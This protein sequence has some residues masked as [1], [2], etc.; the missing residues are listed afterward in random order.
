M[1]ERPI[2]RC[3]CS[4]AAQYHKSGYFWARAEACPPALLW[5]P[6][7]S[8]FSAIK[9]ALP[10]AGGAEAA[11]H[12]HRVRPRTA[13]APTGLAEPRSAAQPGTEQSHTTVPGSRCRPGEGRQAEGG[14][15]APLRAG[16]GREPGS[17]AAPH[18]PRAC[19]GTASLSL[20]GPVGTR[21]P[22]AQH[23]GVGTLPDTLIQWENRQKS[24][25]NSQLTLLAVSHEGIPGRV[26]IGRTAGVCR[27]PERCSQDSRSSLLSFLFQL[28]VELEGRG[29]LGQILPWEAPTARQPPEAPREG[30]G[31]R[32]GQ[33]PQGLSALQVGLSK[34]NLIAQLHVV[35][36]RNGSIMHQI[37]H[38]KEHVSSKHPYLHLS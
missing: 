31:S 38:S 27:S 26:G 8:S 13:T 5:P 37:S 16:R 6:Q 15:A 4:T 3:E 1:D 35:P 29:A 33:W 28:G 34:L 32:R 10:A 2:F 23:S 20:T 9:N 22:T 18:R 36:I 7:W 25:Q 17:G 14:E 11:S 30:T 19:Q 21:C 24:A 12:G